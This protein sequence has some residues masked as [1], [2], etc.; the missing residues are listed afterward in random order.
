MA[1]ES[2]AASSSDP[3]ASVEE[4]L[5][6]T[7][8]RLPLSNRDGKSSERDYYTLNEVARIIGVSYQT[9]LRYK[10]EGY[11]SAIKVGGQFRIPQAEVSSL[12]AGGNPLHVE[13]SKR[14]RRRY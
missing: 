4:S 8:G 3:H 10:D 14:R 6:D 5:T 11:F 7:D 13:E 9:A 12:V 2:R 1:V